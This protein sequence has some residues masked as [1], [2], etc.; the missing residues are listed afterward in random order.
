MATELK[1]D[2]AALQNVFCT[3]VS[4][5][6]GL[7]LLECNWCSH[8]DYVFSSREYENGQA[9]DLEPNWLIKAAVH[10]DKHHAGRVA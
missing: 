4:T 10:M 9:M 8:D 5:E 7:M 1:F 6:E 2:A 3:R